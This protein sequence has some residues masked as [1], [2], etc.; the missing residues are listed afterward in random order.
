[1]GDLQSHFELLSMKINQKLS[2]SSSLAMLAQVGYIDI[3]T[4]FENRK[5]EKESS[6]M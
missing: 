5:Q 3:L 2:L 6:S 4:P 1:M